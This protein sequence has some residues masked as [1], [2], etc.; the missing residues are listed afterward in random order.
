MVHK[1]NFVA[2]IMVEGKVLRESKNQVELPF[3]SEYSVL[4][5]NLDTVRMQAQISIDG[6][7]ATGWLI[8]PAGQSIEV[9]RFVKNLDKGN[10]FKFIE[11]TEAVEEHRGVKAEDGLIRVEFKREKIYESPK[12]VVHH[13]YYHYYPGGCY[14]WPHYYPRTR[15]CTSN[16]LSGTVITRGLSAPVTNTSASGAVNCSY[17]N[18]TTDMYKYSQQ[19]NVQLDCAVNNAGITVP[20]SISNQKFTEVSGFD[21]EPAEALVLHLIGKTNGAPVKVAKTVKTVL[22]CETCGKTSKSSA[23]FCNECGTSLERV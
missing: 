12:V 2:A 17:S 16:S 20:G 13:D 21:T 15:Y 18:S 5:K 10:R 7:A 11:R 4:L 22:E 6:Q 1:S 14:G 23:K 9:E 3:G 19:S 8:I